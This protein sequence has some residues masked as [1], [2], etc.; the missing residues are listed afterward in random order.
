[1]SLFD[2]GFL[3]DH[4]TKTAH[5]KRKLRNTFGKITAEQNMQQTTQAA[6]VLKLVASNQAETNES[7][8]IHEKNINLQ[9]VT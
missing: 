2:S 3:S 7:V 9:C 8:D 1:M 4:L 6:L 5:V